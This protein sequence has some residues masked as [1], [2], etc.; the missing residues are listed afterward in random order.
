[1]ACT[2]LQQDALEQG[3]RSMKSK[4]MSKVFR[5]SFLGIF[6]IVMA[7]CLGPGTT[8]MEGP[9][10]DEFDI[11]A[12]ATAARIRS[13]E[14]IVYAVPD[15]DT[16]E[17]S[18]FLARPNEAREEHESI[19]SVPATEFGFEMGEPLVAP[20]TISFS[21][22]VERAV[23]GFQD[24][25][26]LLEDTTTVTGQPF[27]GFRITPLT[28]FGESAFNPTID[29]FGN[30]VAF[31]TTT[32]LIGTGF[33]SPAGAIS[34]VGTLDRGINPVFGFDGTLGFADPMS[35]RFF[36]NDFVT[37]TRTTF[38]IGNP[39]IFD[40]T[41]PFDTFEAGLTPGQIGGVGTFVGTSPLSIGPAPSQHE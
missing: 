31:E 20:T 11:P 26:F 12:E 37:S 27:L 28:V 39:G 9:P 8:G 40:F 10:L 16:S 5:F 7:G 29:A 17:F 19:V 2:S 25:S 24:G 21:D 34:N 38:D 32:G 3:E 6:L 35:S 30:R 33:V 1:M 13:G 15:D 14:A 22:D 4:K 23:V 18:F 36:I 41:A